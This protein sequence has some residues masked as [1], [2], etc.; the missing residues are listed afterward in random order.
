MSEVSAW[1]E[2]VK[3]E[4]YK[5]KELCFSTELQTWCGVFVRENVEKNCAFCNAYFPAF[6]L[7]CVKCKGEY[8]CPFILDDCQD[9]T[10]LTR[11]SYYL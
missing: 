2:R 5:L 10:L 7:I 11:G 8:S 9:I 1:H 6:K 4:W 3:N